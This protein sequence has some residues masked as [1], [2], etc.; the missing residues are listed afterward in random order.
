MKVSFSKK[1]K[2]IWKNL[3]VDFNFTQYTTIQHGNLGKF[4]LQFS[5]PQPY[6]KL[7]HRIVIYMEIW[8]NFLPFSKSQLYEKLF[9]PIVISFQKTCMYVC[10]RGT[11]RTSLSLA[12]AS[13]RL[14]RRPVGAGGPGGTMALPYFGRLVYP[15]SVRGENYPYHTIHSGRAQYQNGIFEYSSTSLILDLQVL[16]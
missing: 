14:Y 2:K 5:K 10:R 11:D 1:N 13:I 12:R 7:F 9:H 3:P 8:A 15:V 6:K 4:F 16:K